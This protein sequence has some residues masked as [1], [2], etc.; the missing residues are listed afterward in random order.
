MT[1]DESIRLRPVQ[2]GDLPRMYEMQLDPESNRMA[3]TIPRVG[4]AFDL[5]WQQ[6]LDDLAVTARVILD[7]EE[8]IGYI[9][10]F[11]RDGHAPES[12][13]DEE[14][15]QARLRQFATP[16]AGYAATSPQRKELAEMLIRNL[17]TAMIAGPE[18]E[19]ETWKTLKSTGKLDDDALQVVRQL[20]YE[21]MKPVVMPRILLIC[22]SGIG[23][24]R[25]NRRDGD[26]LLLFAHFKALRN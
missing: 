26:G 14:Q 15:V 24:G 8:R 12:P 1:A 16:L 17:W 7:G 25:T 19:E 22:D 6:S 5:H 23:Y 21:Q 20:Y 18:M 11:P 13:M 2:P 3:V 9:A 10:C 4:E